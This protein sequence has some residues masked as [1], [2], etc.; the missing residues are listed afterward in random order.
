MVLLI[1]GD[2]I[3]RHSDQRDQE[4]DPGSDLDRGFF[5]C[6]GHSDIILHHIHVLLVR[7]E[8]HRRHIHRNDRD[9]DGRND[10]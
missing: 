8:G 3:L 1:S 6:L 4:E 2:S 10:V 7:R 5:Q 9:G